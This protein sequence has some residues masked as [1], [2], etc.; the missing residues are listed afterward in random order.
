MITPLVCCL[1]AGAHHAL[2]CPIGIEVIT[3]ARRS[4]RERADFDRLR[5]RIRRDVPRSHAA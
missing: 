1:C 2:D 4:T 3:T 5:I